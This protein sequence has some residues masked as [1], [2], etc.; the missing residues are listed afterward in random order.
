[1]LSVTRIKFNFMLKAEVIIYNNVHNFTYDQTD[2]WT[3][4]R[5]VTPISLA[6]F[7]NTFFLSK[8]GWLK[9]ENLF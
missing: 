8:L 7:S 4:Y 2:P 5:N 1:M 9:N 3:H 6:A